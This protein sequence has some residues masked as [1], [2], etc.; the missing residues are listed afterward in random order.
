MIIQAYQLTSINHI[1]RSNEKEPKHLPEEEVY[2]HLISWMYEREDPGKQNHLV[3]LMMQQL[4]FLMRSTFCKLK[5]CHH[6]LIDFREALEGT[7][8]EKCPAKSISILV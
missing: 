4:L 7:A 6:L 1:R 8:K 2:L 5:Q 3:Y